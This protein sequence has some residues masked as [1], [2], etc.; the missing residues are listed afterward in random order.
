MLLLGVLT[1]AALVV[2]GDL[3]ATTE[4]YLYSRTGSGVILELTVL[5]PFPSLVFKADQNGFTA[6]LR[7]T[8]QLLDTRGEPVAGSAWLT[9]VSTGSYANTRERDSVLSAVF[10]V[11]VPAG[12]VR[13]R[14]DLADLGSDRR[15]WAGFELGR[16]QSGYRVQLFKSGRLNPSGVYGLYDTIEAVFKLEQREGGR[17]DVEPESVIFGFSRSGRE[18]IRSSGTLVD[19][20]GMGVWLLRLPIADS[21][22]RPRIVN[23]YY[24][25]QARGYVADSAVMRSAVVSFYVA[26]PFYYSDSGWRHRVERLIYVASVEEI[27]R[28]RSVPPEHR[29]AVWDSFWRTRD[30]DPVTRVN[31]REEEYFSRIEYADEHFGGADKGYRSDRGRIYVLYGAPDAIES[32]PFEIDR[33]AQQVWYYYTQ[34]LVFLFVDRFGWGEY[35]LVSQEEP[36]GR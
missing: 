9:S 29:A 11:A 36:Y 30:P 33:P 2:Q 14:V 20:A 28:L 23:G 21:L 19:S 7:T 13:G 27:R 15:G 10:E 12:A 32:K 3:K 17:A 25:V 34:G 31:E 26:L 5:V 16:P 35:L 24:E 1:S 8:V 18:L 22:G 6:G 4:A